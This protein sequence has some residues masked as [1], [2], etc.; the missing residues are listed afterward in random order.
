[1]FQDVFFA[2]IE[3]SSTTVEWALSETLKNPKVMEKA[4]AEVRN[5]FSAEGHVNEAG[6]HELKYL[7]A[8]I[9]ET[10]RLH[11]PAPLLAPRECRKNC[12]IFGYEI[13]ARTKVVVNAWAIGRDSKHGSEAER[14][15]PE[16][17]LDSSIDYK[18]NN[19]EYISFG[20]GRRICPSISYGI[21]NIEL[22][23]AQLLY[24]FD[25]N[26]PNGA[27]LEELDMTEAFGITVRRK[28][29]LYL[30]PSTYNHVLVL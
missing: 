1:M 15:Y 13:P 4:Q 23:L 3:T 28:N 18:G 27:K 8:V 26:L 24:Y 11:P 2:G 20:A 19:F 29:D 6:L 5:V 10:L 9:K 30:V 12:E 22:P 7:K 21:A 14:F 25:W 16:R 17:F